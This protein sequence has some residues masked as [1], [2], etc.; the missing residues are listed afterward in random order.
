[1]KW[2]VEHNAIAIVNR[3]MTVSGGAGFMSSHPLSRL[4]RDVR[5]GPFMQPVGEYE[6]MEFV[7]KLT[8]GIDPPIDR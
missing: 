4:Y 7:G 5:A 3:A 8:L 2:T 6:V 1:M